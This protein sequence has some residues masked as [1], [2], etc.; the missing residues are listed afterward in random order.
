MIYS[1]FNKVKWKAIYIICYGM[2]KILS[3]FRSGS[4]ESHNNRRPVEVR[5]WTGHIQYEIKTPNRFVT[6]YPKGLL[7]RV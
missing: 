4:E 6:L 2:F 7:I 3:K 5:S 1:A